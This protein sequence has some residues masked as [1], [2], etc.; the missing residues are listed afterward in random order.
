MASRR[1]K[2]LSIRWRPQPSMCMTSRQQPKC[3]IVMRRWSTRLP[4]TKE[5]KRPEKEGKITTFRI[6]MRPG[7]RRVLSNS[8]EGRLDDHNET[9]K[10]HIRAKGEHPFRVSKQQFGFQKTR[11]RGML[12]NC[13]KVNVLAAL[14]NLYIA[15]YQIP[16]RS[17]ADDWCAHRSR[18]KPKPEGK[19]VNSDEI[20][21][22]R[23]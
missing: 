3:C 14:T 15:R 18:M 10:P 23:H 19:W 22:N 1:S 2:A 4:A 8:A 6:A 12:R 11:Q 20:H 17:C 16:C 13:C 5:S 21:Q 7:K 9:A